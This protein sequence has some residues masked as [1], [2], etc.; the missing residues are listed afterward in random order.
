MGGHNSKSPR[1]SEIPS[2]SDIAQLRAE[3]DA[4]SEA[5]LYA[6]YRK[7]VIDFLL[8]G[9]H[10]ESIWLQVYDYSASDN[11]HKRAVARIMKDLESR[12]FRVKAEVQ[13][14]KK[15][16]LTLSTEGSVEVPYKSG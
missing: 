11:V 7:Q 9:P 16:K 8:D 12:G 1:P 6:S 13:S 14:E 2:A 4:E 5:K 10:R 3:Y 15:T